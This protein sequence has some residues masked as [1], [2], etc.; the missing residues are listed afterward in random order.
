MDPSSVPPSTAGKC[1]FTPWTM[2]R[3]TWSIKSILCCVLRCVKQTAWIR[4]GIHY[5]TTALHPEIST[6]SHIILVFVAQRVQARA[7]IQVAHMECNYAWLI[8]DQ[9]RHHVYVHCRSA[10]CSPQALRWNMEQCSDLPHLVVGNTESLEKNRFHDIICNQRFWLAR[11]KFRPGDN[12]RVGECPDPFLL[13]QKSG[14]TNESPMRENL[15]RDTN[16]S[17]TVSMKERFI[18]VSQN[19]SLHSF[20]ENCVLTFVPYTSSWIWLTWLIR[21]CGKYE[22][23]VHTVHN[24]QS[25]ERLTVETKLITTVH[26]LWTR[27]RSNNSKSCPLSWLGVGLMD[28]ITW[29]CEWPTSEGGAPV[30]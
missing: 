9:W 2:G 3:R 14:H 21:S 15:Y 4:H 24:L 11:S 29:S 28:L 26:Q 27:C 6:P 23:A 22:C 19:I 20:T 7:H 16:F 17:L 30:W 1:S 25:C 12:L 5:K 10:H 18:I 8:S 13:L